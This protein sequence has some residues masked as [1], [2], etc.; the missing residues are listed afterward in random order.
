MAT[1]ATP[2]ASGVDARTMVLPLAL[3]MQG[4]SS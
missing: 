1:A 2:A 4:R 3:A